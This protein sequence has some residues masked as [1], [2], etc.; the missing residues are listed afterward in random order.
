MF[1]A[2][3]SESR[4]HYDDNI[5]YADKSEI[6]DDDKVLYTKI[7]RTEISIDKVLSNLLVLDEYSAYRNIVLKENDE[8]AFSDNEDIFSNHSSLKTSPE[9][10]NLHQIKGKLHLTFRAELSDEFLKRI[11]VVKKLYIRDA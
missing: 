5:S 9:F 11:E 8:G 1:D 4:S 7:G 2:S 3:D 6:D 10:N